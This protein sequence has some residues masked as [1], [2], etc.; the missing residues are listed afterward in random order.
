MTS[1]PPSSYQHPGAPP[2]RPELPEGVERPPQPPRSVPVWAPFVAM[3]VAF[4]GG[5]IAFALLALATGTGSVDSPPQGVTLGATLVQD[6]LLV[7][8]ALFAVRAYEGGI[9]PA[10]LG[11]RRTALWPA[12]RAAAVVIVG[13]Y[14]FQ[15]V[16][17]VIFG[18]PKNQ[19]LVNDLKAEH[20]ELVLAS[21]AVLVCV[22]A[23]IAEE[24]FFRG[25]MFR[26]FSDRLGVAAGVLLSSA[27]FGLA[28][29]P[30]SPIETGLSLFALGVGFALLRWK[31]G[32]LLPS[33]ALHAAN[34]SL[35]FGVTLTLAWPVFILVLVGSTA[36]VLA[37]GLRL[38]TSTWRG[39][40]A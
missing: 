3:L 29:L 39:L 28:H 27:V 18:A 13:W 34:N 36:V 25:F 32:S 37:T 30:G 38:T 8:A 31:T 11:L 16:L 26:V 33:M 10:W 6:A 4:V 2:A 23:P 21:Y 19:D 15:V 17:L 24:I 12:V 40:N 1:V 20:S 9:R 14:L 22:L 35:S 5:T 7:A